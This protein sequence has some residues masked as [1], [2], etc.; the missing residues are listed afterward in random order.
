M[1]VLMDWDRCEANGMCMRA[2]PE[3]FLL[4][5]DDKLTILQET[6][7]EELRAKLQLAVRRCPKQAISIE[8]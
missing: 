7:P 8:E 6:P 2:A 1:R 3:I 4:G 5:E